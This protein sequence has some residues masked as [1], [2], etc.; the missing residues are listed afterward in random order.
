[1]EA[2]GKGD[3]TDLGASVASDINNRGLVVGWVDRPGQR[4]AFV[5]DTVRRDMRLLPAL[6]P[7][8]LVFEAHAVNEQGLVIGDSDMVPVVWDL[9]REPIACEPLLAREEIAPHG[10]VAYAINRQGEIVGW[11]HRLNLDPLGFLCAWNREAGKAERLSFDVANWK[12]WAVNDE[13]DIAGE[14]YP[15]PVLWQVRKRELHL[16]PLLDGASWGVAQGVS[17]QPMA[18]GYCGAKGPKRACVWHFECGEV[19]Y[20]DH[21]A[22]EPLGALGGSE[23]GS[24]ALAVNDKGQVVGRSET[25]P[26]SNVWHACLWERDQGGKWSI[27]DLGALP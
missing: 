7:D 13:L 1:M 10:S 2:L 5:W 20:L 25:A 19:H 11:G 9:G 12:P 3:G 4:S 22:V 8:H 23:C 24:E 15:Y 21:W 14:L 16:L 6:S 18:V 27:R 17:A 26:G